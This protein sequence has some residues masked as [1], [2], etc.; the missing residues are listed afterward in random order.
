MKTS[1]W[2]FLCNGSWLEA[3]ERKIQNILFFFFFKHNT[4]TAVRFLFPVCGWVPQIFKYFIV[5]FRATFFPTLPFHNYFWLM[6]HSFTLFFILY[7]YKCLVLVVVIV[8]VALIT[9]FY[10]R[11]VEILGNSLFFISVLKVL[12][13]LVPAQQLAIRCLLV[14]IL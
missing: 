14:L 9:L 13:F 2:G 1:L 7:N 10:S 11:S 3:T 4:N 5:F 6:L 8:D 12:F